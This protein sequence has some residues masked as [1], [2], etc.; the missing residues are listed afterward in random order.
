[1]RKKK[2][3]NRRCDD[4]GKVIAEKS[5]TSHV[6]SHLFK[7]YLR[8]CEFCYQEIERP[9]YEYHLKGCKKNPD[10]IVRC[11][12]CKRTVMKSGYEHHLVECEENPDNKVECEYCKRIISK[13]TYEPHLVNCKKNPGNKVKCRYCKQTMKK[14]KYDLHLV[15]CAKY[16]T[17]IYCEFCKQEVWERIG[18]PHLGKCRNAPKIIKCLCGERVSS[19]NVQEHKKCV[20][21]YLTRHLLGDLLGEQEVIAKRVSWR[22]LPPGE[23]PFEK[24]LSHYESLNRKYGDDLQIDIERLKSVHSLCPEAIYVG[25]DEFERYIVFYFQEAKTAVLECPVVGNATYIIRGDWERLSRLSKKELLE[26]YHD[27]V[28]RLVHVGDW[29]YKLKCKVNALKKM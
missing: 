29:L 23:H 9:K 18:K 28:A 1:V 12:H 6:V 19:F 15:E 27:N 22:L 7:R 21:E 8:I 11:E 24:I 20:L 10:N 2:T 13:R 17:K 4:C 26:S 25:T 3:P 14:S 5:Y 16:Y